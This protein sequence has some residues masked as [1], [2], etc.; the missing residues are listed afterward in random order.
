MR[1]GSKPHGF[2]Q[3]FQRFAYALIVIDDDDGGLP[4]LPFID[5]RVFP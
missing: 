3:P 5:Q 2:E 1:F 4:V